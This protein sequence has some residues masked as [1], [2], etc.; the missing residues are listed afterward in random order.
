MWKSSRIGL[1]SYPIS[2]SAFRARAAGSVLAGPAR[3]P[4]VVVRASA[5]IVASFRSPLMQGP[6][7]PVCFPHG[8]DAGTFMLEC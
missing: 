4:Y 2:L 8:P 6:T 3:S 7:P 1:T 5:E